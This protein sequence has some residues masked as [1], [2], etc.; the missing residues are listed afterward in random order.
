M[1]HSYKNI[2]KIIVLFSA[3]NFFILFQLLMKLETAVFNTCEHSVT[4]SVRLLASFFQFKFRTFQGNFG[5]T[6]S[7]IQD[8]GNRFQKSFSFHSQIVIGST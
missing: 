6:A 5:A 3:T 4:A 7:L 8:F 1:F 2:P